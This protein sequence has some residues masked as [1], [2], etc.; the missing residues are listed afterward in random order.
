MRVVRRT[1]EKEELEYRT[2]TL[3][4]KKETEEIEQER[5]I[6]VRANKTDV[7]MLVRDISRRER[8]ST[9]DNQRARQD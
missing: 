2:Q 7:F 5:G 4:P 6:L 9:S 3:K 8:K 1:E